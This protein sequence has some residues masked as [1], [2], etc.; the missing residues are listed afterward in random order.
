MV[1]FDPACG[2]AAG[3]YLSG[4]RTHCV[5]EPYHR[6]YFPA[7][8][9]CDNQPP[10]LGGLNILVRIALTD[11]E[12]DVFF[13]PGQRFA[14]WADAIAG[15]TIRGEGLV[16]YGVISCQESPPPPSADDRAAHRAR[17]DPASPSP[18]M[19]SAGAPT[20]GSESSC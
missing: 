7:L 18:F 16:G 11:P 2:S 4:A 14:I 5:I 20:G 8:I 10:P 1:A 17:A 3:A 19:P 12:A 13:A 6:K 15:K 9:S